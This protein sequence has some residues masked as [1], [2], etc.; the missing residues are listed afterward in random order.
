MSNTIMFAILIF[1]LI[2]GPSL[3][4]WVDSLTDSFKREYCKVWLYRKV[5]SSYVLTRWYIEDFFYM[6]RAKCILYWRL[7][8]L[9]GMVDMHLIIRKYDQKHINNKENESLQSFKMD[10]NIFPY[11]DEEEQEEY[12]NNCREREAFAR[13]LQVL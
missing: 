8:W 13:E 2:S 11:L 12:K 7:S 4:V 10:M 9:G 5:R 3:V 1:L 6:I